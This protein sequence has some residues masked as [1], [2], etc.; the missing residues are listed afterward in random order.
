M[1]AFTYEL[2]FRYT[3]TSSEYLGQGRVS[4]SWG[5][6]SRSYERNYACPRPKGSL[7]LSHVCE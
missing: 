5:S 2:H 7:V 4:R 1:N 3:D 6:R